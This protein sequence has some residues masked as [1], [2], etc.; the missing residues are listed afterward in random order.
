MRYI[1]TLYWF[2]RMTEAFVGEKTFEALSDPLVAEIL[3]VPVDEILS[4]EWP[5]D[6]ERAHRLEAAA[7]YKPDVTQYDYFLGAETV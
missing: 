2:D 4:G 6:A 7:G 5:V 1:W 3:G